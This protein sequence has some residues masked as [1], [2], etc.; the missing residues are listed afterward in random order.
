L[1]SEDSRVDVAFADLRAELE[2]LIREASG[3]FPWHNNG[4]YGPHPTL[5]DEQ[6]KAFEDTHRIILP[7]EYRGFLTHIGN[8]GRWPWL[9]QER[10]GRIE[11]DSWQ[12]GDGWV[13]TLSVPFPHIIAWN[14]PSGEPAYDEERDGDPEYVQQIWEW[15]Q[16]YFSAA[17]INGAMPLHDLGCGRHQWLIVT[18]P[19]A[20]GVWFDG[21]G[22]REGLFPVLSCNGG[23]VGFM[24]WMRLRIDYALRHVRLDKARMPNHRA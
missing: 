20:G 2:S 21:R 12:E 16:R 4:V 19:L 18:G 17:L 10:L 23:R 1:I 5:T 11:P 15:K 3:V 6:L 13:G 9:V 8:G 14:D 7:P 22:D 24:D